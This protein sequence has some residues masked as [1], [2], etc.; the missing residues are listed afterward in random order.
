MRVTNSMTYQMLTGYLMNNRDQMYTLQEQTSSGKKVQRPSDDPGA[1]DLIS[2]MH[3]QGSMLQQYQKNTSR[4]E[5]DLLSMDSQLQ[6][7]HDQVLRASEAMVSGGDGTKSTVDLQA[8]GEELNQLLEEIVS[9]ANASPEDGYVFSGLRQS[10]AAYDVERNEDGDIISMTYQGSE[11]TR[12]IEIAEGEY[13]PAT[14][15]G[16]DMD[17]ENGIFQTATND[18]FADI[19]HARD[20]LKAGENLSEPDLVTCD[21]VTDTIATND[22]YRTGRSVMLSSSET[23]PDGLSADTTYYAIRIS[24]NEI[25]LASS[26]ANARAGVAVDFT[27]TGS[28]DIRMGQNHLADINRSEEQMM[29][30]LTRL[31]AYEERVSLTDTLLRAKENDMNAKLESEEDVDM[32]KA[33]M[34]LTNKQAAYEAS[35]RVTTTTMQ[36]SLLN[37]L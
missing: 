27:T 24:D 11:E 32:T 2:T 30:V 6:H 19:I 36:S 26:L 21:P 9:V 3:Q 12:N 10:V 34:D 37:Y 8:L 17:G 25:Q 7:A 16:S 20:R 5:G 31:G 35:L 23:L 4:L 29:G 14:L 33:I 22:L 28:G 18:L 13:L 1:Y 15:V